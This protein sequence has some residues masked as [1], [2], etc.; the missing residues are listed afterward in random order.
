M[1]SSRGAPEDVVKAGLFDL[2]GMAD[3]FNYNYPDNIGFCMGVNPDG[4]LPGNIDAAL[5]DFRAVGQSPHAVGFK[6]YP[7]YYHMPISDPAYF[8]IFELAEELDLPV[9][10]HTGDTANTAGRLRFSHPLTVDD[11]AAMFPRVNFVM[12]HFGNPWAMEA[13]EVCKNKPNVY[14]DLSGLAVGTP[15]AE[16]FYSRY[17]GYVRHLTTWL[18]YLDSYDKVMWGTD[19]PLVNLER[20]IELIAGM[21]PE[22]AHDQFFYQTALKVYKKLGKF[23]TN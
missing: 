21:I 7:G 9:A 4:L 15:D 18:E 12:C 13:A 10:V 5:A 19:W 1:G 20:Y 3:P 22:W 16:D 23:I 11:A 14:A 2:E 6:L 8:P 17:G